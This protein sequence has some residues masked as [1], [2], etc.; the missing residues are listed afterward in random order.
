MSIVIVDDSATNLIVLKCL[1]AAAGKPNAI[2]FTGGMEALNALSGMRCELVIVDY[3]M[4][5][6]DGIEFITH[7]R[8]DP[9]HIDTP[10]IMV[11]H[12]AERDVRLRALDAGATD[13]LSKPVDPAEFKARVRNLCRRPEAQVSLAS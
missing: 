6:L 4:P 10:V 5:D 9:L 8:R 1:S 2:T 12:S 13:F 11:T 3:S 7:L